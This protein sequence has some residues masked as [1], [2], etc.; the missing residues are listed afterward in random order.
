MQNAIR[1]QDINRLRNR[2]PSREAA[3]DVRRLSLTLDG[4]DAALLDSVADFLLD[5]RQALRG[6]RR[7]VRG[8]RHWEST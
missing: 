4:T 8:S 7:D 3:E 1:P 5:A 2:V 6:G